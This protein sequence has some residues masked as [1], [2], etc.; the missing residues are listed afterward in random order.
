[1]SMTFTVTVFAVGCNTIFLDDTDA[2]GSRI[3]YQSL[4]EPSLFRRQARCFGR[5]SS[6][7]Y[8]PRSRSAPLLLCHSIQPLAATNITFS[9]VTISGR[10]SDSASSLS[11]ED[12]FAE[13]NSVL[14]TVRE[15]RSF[16]PAESF[17]IAPAG[18][19]YS[20][21]KTANVHCGRRYCAIL[22]ALL[23]KPLYCKP[24]LLSYFCFLDA[25]VS[26]RYIVMSLLDLTKNPTLP[27]NIEHPLF[28]GPASNSS[29]TKHFFNLPHISP[30]TKKHY[31][32]STFDFIQPLFMSAAM[33][34][35]F[36]VTPASFHS[37]EDKSYRR[38]NK[39]DIHFLEE[40]FCDI[41]YPVEDTLCC[42]LSII[43][44]FEKEKKEEIA[45]ED[46]EEIALVTM[47]IETVG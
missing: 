18:G 29:R 4:P 38:C 44:T 25:D 31:L 32:I 13:K 19:G 46:K 30:S 11:Y 6:A 14:L 7:R 3:S 27:N 15:T 22:A 39:T 1:M 36:W 28:Q 5:F 20:S 35:S 47:V 40:R 33:Q 8:N 43:T 23:T 34:A 2:G 26:S 17:G 37:R 45:P 12:L 16:Y 10:A 9:S 42:A 24:S 21:S 41:V